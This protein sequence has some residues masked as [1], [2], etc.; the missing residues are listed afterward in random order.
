ILGRTVNSFGADLGAELHLPQPN[1][2]PDP[3]PSNSD[4]S[5]QQSPKFEQQNYA[6]SPQPLEILG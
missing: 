6:L 3:V 1:F 2:S 4:H 5:A